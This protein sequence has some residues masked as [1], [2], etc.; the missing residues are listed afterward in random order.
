MPIQPK[1]FTLKCPNCNWSKRIHPKSDVVDASWGLQYGV[2]P[3]CGAKTERVEGADAISD[4]V[5]AIKD[6]FRGRSG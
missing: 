6:I 3:K 1:P 2:C 4:A 5:D